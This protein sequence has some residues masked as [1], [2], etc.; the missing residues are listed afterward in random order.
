[1]HAGREMHDGRAH[2]VRGSRGPREESDYRGGDSRAGAAELAAVLRVGQPH[3][4]EHGVSQH[5]RREPARG[6]Q[7]HRGREWRVDF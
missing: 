1:M 5:L 2:A 6:K 4:R 7:R 3:E